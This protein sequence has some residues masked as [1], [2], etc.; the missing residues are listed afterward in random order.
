MKYVVRAVFDIST[1]KHSL[2]LIKVNNAVFS[3]QINNKGQ[4]KIKVDF[5]Y[6]GI[7]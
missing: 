7:L 1:V 2:V 3:K 4:E 6:N 5:I